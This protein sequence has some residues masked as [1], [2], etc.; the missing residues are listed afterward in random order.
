MRQYRNATNMTDRAAALGVLA[1]RHRGSDAARKAL[2]DFEKRYADDALVL[3]KWF[4]VQAS[5]PGGATVETVASLTRHPAYSILNPNRVRSLV[6]TFSTANQTA[7]HRADGAGYRFLADTILE[8]EKRNPQVA[9]RLATAFRSWRSLEAGRQ[10]KA[11]EALVSIARP[12]NFRP[13]VATSSSGRWPDAEAA[14]Q[15]QI[16]R[17]LAPTYGQAESRLIL[18]SRFGSAVSPN[19]H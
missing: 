19:L 18:C 9:A 7:F 17:F 15:N 10:A 4:Q 12:R 1:H 11:R 5:V 14:R 2:A 16:S 8:V 13:T 6:G 3:D